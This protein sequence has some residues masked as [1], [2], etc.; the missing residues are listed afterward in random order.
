MSL[1][2]SFQ[3]YFGVHGF[4]SRTVSSRKQGKF[5]TCMMFLQDAGA[6]PVV[7]IIVLSI[8]VTQPIIACFRPPPDD[9]KRYSNDSWF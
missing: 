6:H 3:K 5:L 2:L 4:I 8:A 1:I 9:G 7:G